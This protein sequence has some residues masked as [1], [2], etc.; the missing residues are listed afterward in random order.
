MEVVEI[1]QPSNPVTEYRKALAPPYDLPAS[2]PLY[3]KTWFQDGKATEEQAGVCKKIKSLCGVLC[4]AIERLATANSTEAVKQTKEET[5]IDSP[6][7]AYAWVG[8]V[9]KAIRIQVESILPDSQEKKDALESLE[10]I[11]ALVATRH[12]LE[13]VKIVRYYLMSAAIAAVLQ[14]QEE[15][16]KTSFSNMES[17][18]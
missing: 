10:E 9:Q 2:E 18:K 3:K 12:Y 13:A 14:C 16:T 4:G 7:Q 8:S 15:G 1:K 5:D 17:G 11:G 6:V